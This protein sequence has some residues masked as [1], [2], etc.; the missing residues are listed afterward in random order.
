MTYLEKHKLKFNSPEN[1][2][3]VQDGLK[4]LKTWREL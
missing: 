1:M 4:Y 3:C 2:L